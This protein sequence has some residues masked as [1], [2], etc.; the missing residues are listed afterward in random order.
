MEGMKTNKK[1]NKDVILESIQ[2]EAEIMTRKYELHEQVV[3]INK[4]LQGLYESNHLVNT[5]GFKQ[6]HDGMNKTVSGFETT[7][8]ISYIA[9]L[10]KEMGEEKIDETINEVEK[11][12]EYQQEIEKLKNEVAQ[13]KASATK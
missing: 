10:E 7:P 6:P 2:K 1:I 3:I 12:K 13:L 9:Q 5:F 8:N 11:Y 4:E